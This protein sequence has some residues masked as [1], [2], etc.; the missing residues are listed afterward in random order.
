LQ[1]DGVGTSEGVVQVDK[2]IV[3]GSSAPCRRMDMDE[4]SHDVIIGMPWLM[5][6]GLVLVWNG[7]SSGAA[8]QWQGLAG[9]GETMVS[10]E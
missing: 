9:L 5:S 7:E 3:D 8:G 10:H 4:L 1:T 2:A 6:G